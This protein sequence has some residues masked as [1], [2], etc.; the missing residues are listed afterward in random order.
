MENLKLTPRRLQG[1]CGIYD[2][3]DAEKCY[4]KIFVTEGGRVLP[5]NGRGITED[6]LMM[7]F[8]WGRLEELESHEAAAPENGAGFEDSYYNDYSWDDDQVHEYRADTPLVY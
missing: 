7:V 5:I 4:T 6:D 1:R 3:G 2:A 8:D